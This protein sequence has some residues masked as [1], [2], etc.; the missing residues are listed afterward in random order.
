MYLLLVL[1]LALRPPSQ[2]QLTVDSRGFV[3]TGTNAS[4]T[5]YTE[6]SGG[7]NLWIVLIS[8]GV[9]GLLSTSLLP[10]TVR[11][12]ASA[13]AW[14][15]IVTL[16]FGV[17]HIVSSLGLHQGWQLG[18]FALACSAGHALA[19]RARPKTVAL[20]ADYH[21]VGGA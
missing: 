11:P 18:A 6:F 10:R 1:S 3:V 21:H 5:F 12:L 8:I 15:F 19:L 17:G 2:A 4:S 13:H 14:M 20:G 9:F 7:V 16:A